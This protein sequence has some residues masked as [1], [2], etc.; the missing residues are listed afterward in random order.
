M[1]TPALKNNK[2]NQQFIADKAET[3]SD[4]DGISYV[5]YL[6]ETDISYTDMMQIF[7]QGAGGSAVTDRKLALLTDL[8]FVHRIAKEA[9]DL[10]VSPKFIERIGALALVADH[11]EARQLAHH[12]ISVHKPDVPVRVFSTL[13]HG[14]LWL[15]SL[16]H[17]G[18]IQ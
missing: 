18:T 1:A 16:L 10:T 13:E 17:D 7:L 4:A 2:L 8:R 5:R 3:W 6:P 14:R 12:Y 9:L 15:L 11:L